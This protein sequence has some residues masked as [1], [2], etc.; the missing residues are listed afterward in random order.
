[1]AVPP[2]SSS[3][4]NQRWDEGRVFAGHPD[5]FAKTFEREVFAFTHRLA[6]NPLFELE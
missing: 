5:L 6:D 1:M 4:S 3:S 2:L